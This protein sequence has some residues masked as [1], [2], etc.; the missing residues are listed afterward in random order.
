MKH[1]HMILKYLN[2]GKGITYIF[3]LGLDFSPLKH[4]FLLRKKKT[5]STLRTRENKGRAK[6][7]PAVSVPNGGSE[8]N[9]WFLHTDGN[10]EGNSLVVL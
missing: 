7:H 10:R 4:L 6:K 3:L 5:S 1:I 2:W 8:V 9:N